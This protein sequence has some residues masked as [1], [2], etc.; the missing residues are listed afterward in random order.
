MKELFM[1]EK[2]LGLTAISE[3]QVYTNYI[4]KELN[5]LSVIIS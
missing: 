2:V 5:M 3:A 1:S 4:V